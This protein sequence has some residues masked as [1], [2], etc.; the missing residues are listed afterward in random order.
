[1]LKKPESRRILSSLR[2]TSSSLL[3]LRDDQ[4]CGTQRSTHTET[5]EF[6]DSSFEFD[7]EVFRSK[8][9]LTAMRSHLKQAVKISAR[10]I[11]NGS[12][13]SKTNSIKIDDE[14]KLAARGG[15][16]QPSVTSKKLKEPQL[17]DLIPSDTGIQEYMTDTQSI[18]SYEPFASPP[19][20]EKKDAEEALNFP[21][22][23]GNFTPQANRHTSREKDQILQA[24]LQVP[25][26]FKSRISDLSSSRSSM[27]NASS[28]THI[29]L[30]GNA[31]TSA[32]L[33]QRSMKL[34]YGRNYTK[35]A[36]E[37]FRMNILHKMILNMQ[38]LLVL[39]RDLGVS[40]DPGSE[41]HAHVISTVKVA[42]VYDCLPTSVSTALAV[43]WRDPGILNT[44]RGGRLRWYWDDLE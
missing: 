24:N 31:K 6:L 8:V 2:D 44:F 40:L 22:H 36:K 43:L 11:R 34:A 38:S 3:W 21:F 37:A 25:S 15:G 29:L 26:L 12:T 16:R 35:V 1:M 39:T 23:D 9:Y 32:L 41:L 27:Y 20:Y 7:A 5:S 28:E 18:T 19:A 30:T 4:S 42:D 33:F 17:Y 13:N 10:K 14:R